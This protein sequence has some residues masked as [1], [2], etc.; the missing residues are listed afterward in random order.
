MVGFGLVTLMAFVRIGTDRRVFEPPISTADAI[1]AVRSLMA[2]SNV[3]IVEPTERHWAILAE[4]AAKGQVRGS[5]ITD[6]HLAALAIEHG[7]T[8]AT[9]DRGFARFPGLKLTYPL[10]A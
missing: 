3:R 9:N 1:V 2:R 5:G 7:A 8:F 10:S 4:I 6:A